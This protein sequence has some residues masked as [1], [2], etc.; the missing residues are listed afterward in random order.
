MGEKDKPEISRTFQ[1]QKDGPEQSM[2]F[3]DLYRTAEET[4][5]TMTSLLVAIGDQHSVRAYMGP[6]KEE[7]TAQDKCIRKFGGAEKFLTDV[8]RGKIE[9]NS[10][11]DLASVKAIFE[12]PDSV[13]LSNRKISLEGKTDNFA[14]PKAYTSYRG[15][16]YKLGVET[17]DGKPHV[18]ELQIVSPAMEAVY[19]ITHHHKRIA[20][21]I[22][23]EAAKENRD[24]TDDEIEQVEQH[25]AV[26]Q[27]Y[28]S[29]AACKEGYDRFLEDT[30]HYA[31]T[32]ERQAHLIERMAQIGVPSDI[33]EKNS[34]DTKE[35][36][37]LA[38]DN[39]DE[40][41]L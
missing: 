23:N 27:Y 20:E 39:E 11:E 6:I 28:N 24:L 21:E 8:V 40:L 12:A 5:R 3:R 36:P 22:Y 15:L 25:Y 2:S 33:D 10:A 26:C 29:K 4:N 18:V 31:F 34:S 30:K 37:D 1:Q 13:M 17:D 14:N 38:T 7:K 41:K 32:P 16:Q 35:N 19:D 9:V